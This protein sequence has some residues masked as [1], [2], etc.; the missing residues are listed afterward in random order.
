MK[1]RRTATRFQFKISGT[2]EET[3]ERTHR[4][5]NY[6][7]SMA[8]LYSC[9]TSSHTSSCMIEANEKRGTMIGVDHRVAT[10]GQC[11]TN[12]K[13]QALWLSSLHF[14][15]LCEAPNCQSELN[16]QFVINW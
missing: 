12:R 4:H 9:C 5:E 1:A 15:S 2:F 6:S 11:T 16:S 8:T 3:R 10:N 13:I 14:S 7:S